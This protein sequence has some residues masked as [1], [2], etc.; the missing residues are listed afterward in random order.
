[1]HPSLLRNWF[2]KNAP[3]FGLDEIKEDSY[4][5]D[6]NIEDV[7]NKLLP[8]NYDDDVDAYDSVFVNKRQEKKCC[9]IFSV[10]YLC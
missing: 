2:G 1:M 3:N 9:L 6:D 5:R 8:I 4:E 7:S 10:C